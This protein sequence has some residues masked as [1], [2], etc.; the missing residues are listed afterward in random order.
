MFFTQYRFWLMGQ[1]AAAYLILHSSCCSMTP[2]EL[3][4]GLEMFL[5]IPF[6]NLTF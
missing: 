6:E 2:N 4:L 5:N 3:I 1:W